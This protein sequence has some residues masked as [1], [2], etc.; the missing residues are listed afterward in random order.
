MKIDD[1]FK[2]VYFIDESHQFKEEEFE[3]YQ[4]SRFWLFRHFQRNGE[5]LK[6]VDSFYSKIDVSELIV[7]LV[8]I[9]R[10]LKWKIKRKKCILIV[11]HTNRKRNNNT[12]DPYLGNLTNDLESEWPIISIGFLDRGCRA[13]LKSKN[14]AIIPLIYFN[15]FR[16]INSLL[17]VR[18]QVYNLDTQI[19]ICLKDSNQQILYDAKVYRKRLTQ[20]QSDNYLFKRIINLLRPSA[21][22]CV[23]GYNNNSSFVK[24]CKKKS[25]PTFEIQ[26]GILFKN[27]IG[28][29]YGNT[30]NFTNAILVD[31]LIIWGGFWKSQLSRS[32][33][34]QVN[35]LE[36]TYELGAELLKNSAAYDHINGDVL[37]I[38]QPSASM[39]ISDHISEIRNRH[40][41]LKIG[42]K[43]HPKMSRIKPDWEGI[44][45]FFDE[46]IYALFRSYKVIVGCFS[47]ALFEAK[48]IGKNVYYIDHEGFSLYREC[49]NSA[50]IS[51]LSLSDS[52]LSESFDWEN[53]NN[54]IGEGALINVFKRGFTK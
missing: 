51:P 38:M 54:I 45:I 5:S 16:K 24:A 42:V 41:K 8:S 21:F 39:V 22:I 46:N 14:K 19:E 27:H 7:L 28:Y 4:Q 31:N 36:G 1:Y 44:D 35:I 23:D 3:L 37:F 18:K 25:I 43:Y 30:L 32:F 2:A 40:P 20:I 49:L 13:F 48:A 10:I 33:S 15:A 29:S 52:V 12:K 9:F 50:G 26:H 17:T 6:G 47:T 11:E 34:D 53:Q